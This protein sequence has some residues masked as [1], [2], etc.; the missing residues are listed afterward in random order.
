MTYSHYL[1]QDKFRGQTTTG[2]VYLGDQKG[3]VKKSDKTAKDLRNAHFV[4]GSSP[5][6]YLTEH[7][8]EFYKKQALM[9][10]KQKDDQTQ[11]VGNIRGHH[12]N[13]GENRPT[14]LTTNSAAF[15]GAQGDGN[16][17]KSPTIGKDLRAAH[18]DLGKE[19]SPFVTTSQLDYSKKVRSNINFIIVYSV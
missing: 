16:R 19:G 3:A 15:N 7:Q 2:S 18:F 1:G 4:L 13:F 14:Y 5:G 9:K 10:K 12:F 8:H 6:S 17:L 11:L